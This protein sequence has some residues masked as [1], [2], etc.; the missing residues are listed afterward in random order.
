[1]PSIKKAEYEGLKLKVQLW[2]EIS[3]HL[4]EALEAQ[5]SE[6]KKWKRYYEAVRETLQVEAFL[7]IPGCFNPMDAV[8]YLVKKQEE[9]NNEFDNLARQMR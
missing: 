6:A 9:V 8:E 3:N 4:G 7:E 2:K 1:M 5:T